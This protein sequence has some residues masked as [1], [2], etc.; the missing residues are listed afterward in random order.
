MP[1][2]ARQHHPL[3]N[4]QRAD[5]RRLAQV[6]PPVEHV[7]RRLKVLYILKKTYR[8]RRRRVHLR[9]NFMAALCNRFPFQT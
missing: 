4:T 2:N 3:M 5:H 6:R 9:V 7:I 8:H 1:K